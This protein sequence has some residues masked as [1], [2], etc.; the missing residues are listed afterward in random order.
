MLT[1]NMFHV[2]RN[3]HYILGNKVWNISIETDVKHEN[4]TKK[5]RINAIFKRSIVENEYIP[6]Y[7]Y[8]RLNITE[9]AEFSQ[10]HNIWYLYDMCIKEIRK[11]K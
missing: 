9:T 8:K 7:N 3:I 5:R 10:Q 2:K 11:R 1:Q 4:A 6:W